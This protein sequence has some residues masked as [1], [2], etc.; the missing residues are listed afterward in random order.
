MLLKKINNDRLIDGAIFDVDGT[1]LDTMPVWHDAGA[2]Y[3]ATMGI[4]AEEDL[5]D[6]L[7]AETV[8]TGAEYM[9]ENYGLKQSVEEVA[10]GINYQM[11][12]F[13]F[14]EAPLKEGALE[15][16]QRM[17]AAGTK[18]TVA[19]S[20]DRYCIEAAFDRL[21]ISDLFDAV[22]TCGEIGATKSK[23]DIFYEAVEVM[24]TQIPDT[25]VFEDGLYA[26]KTARAEGFRTVGVYDKVSE[27]DQQ[28]IM[29]YADFYYKSL[30]DFEII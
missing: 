11:E 7:F 12:R 9:I 2:R 19:T 10:D 14:E 27:S 24:G 28:E 30:A 1:L 26:I 4:E 8:V 13:Y 15:L 23:P 5:G 20:T 22:L 18:L 3:L 29:R 25:W 6:R 16:V 21:G 17:K